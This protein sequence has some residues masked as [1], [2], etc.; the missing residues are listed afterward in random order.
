MEKKTL[1]NCTIVEKICKI[2]RTK[3]RCIRLLST[4]S[5]GSSD[6][7][8]RPPESKRSTMEAWIECCPKCHYCAPNIEEP[9]DITDKFIWDQE[10]QNIFPKSDKVPELQYRF[11]GWAKCAEFLKLYNEASLAHLH[12]AWACDDKIIE[13]ELANSSFKSDEPTVLLTN[14]IEFSC[15]RRKDAYSMLEEALNK[16]QKLID[17]SKCD[18][19]IA[20]DLLRRSGQ[21]KQ[22]NIY[23]NKHFRKQDDDEEEIDTYDRIAAY[24]SDLSEMKDKKA[25]KISEAL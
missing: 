14:L 24:Q 18:H 20:L 16:K 19:I 11:L 21:F 6:L 23:L 5:L 13:E 3:C 17:G 12:A 1:S 2:C 15:W 25:H 9:N 8:T 4:N 22:V 7:D 10:Y